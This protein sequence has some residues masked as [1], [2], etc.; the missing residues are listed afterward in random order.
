MI[1]RQLYKLSYN[2]VISKEGEAERLFKQRRVVI[3]FIGIGA[4]IL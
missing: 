4:L 1:R 3:Y 2:R